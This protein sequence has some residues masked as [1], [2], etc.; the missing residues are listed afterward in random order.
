MTCVTQHDLTDKT[1][2]DVREC[3]ASS[4]F[5]CPMYVQSDWVQVTVEETPLQ[6]GLLGLLCSSSSCCKASKCVGS[7]CSPC[8]KSAGVHLYLFCRGMSKTDSYLYMQK[9][10]ICTRNVTLYFSK[11]RFICL[12]FN[13]ISIYSSIST[14]IV[15]SKEDVSVSFPCFTE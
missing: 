5:K 1:S 9:T 13:Y 14:I 11:G 4:A 12:A 7:T 3:S 10:V 6:S 2:C 8:Q 15:A